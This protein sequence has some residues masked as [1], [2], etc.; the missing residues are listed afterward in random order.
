MNFDIN[1]E[2]QTVQCSLEF[3]SPLDKVWQAWTN[4]QI[5]SQWWAPAPWKAETKSQDFREGGYWVYAMVSPEG[6]KH[7]AR[8]DYT[9]ILHENSLAARDSFCDSE[10][11]VNVN[12]P[13]ASWALHF[14]EHNNITKVDVALRFDSVEDLDE[15]LKMG[16]REGFTK[17]IENLHTLLSE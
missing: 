14:I 13:R 4:E 8:F 3:N 7:W 5:L 9:H 16:F 2:T 10:G 17:A 6:E 1:K 12:M 15:L 11:N